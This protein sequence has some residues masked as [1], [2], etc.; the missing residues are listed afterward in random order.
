MRSSLK[1]LAAAALVAGSLLVSPAE[2]SAELPTLVLSMKHEN[3]LLGDSVTLGCDNE[4][5]TGS[6]PRRAAACKA[7][8]LAD[9]DFDRLQPT[10]QVCTLEYNPVVARAVG[11][12]HGKKI[13]FEKTYGNSCEAATKSAD[14][15]HW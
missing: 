2:A 4:E 6:H 12:W 1:P 3:A 11:R 8:Q 10:N 7:I 5:A 15:F 14:V 9:G 13:T